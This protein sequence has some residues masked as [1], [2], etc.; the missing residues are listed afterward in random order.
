[1]GD[2]LR[3]R[4]ARPRRPVLKS[5]PPHTFLEATLSAV[6][7]MG[8]LWRLYDTAIPICAGTPAG[9]V[10]YAVGNDCAG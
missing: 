9:R 3:L 1:M 5:H 7:I 4:R 2:V 6:R 8:A 10:R